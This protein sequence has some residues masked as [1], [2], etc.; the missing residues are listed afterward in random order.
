[1]YAVYVSVY[2]VKNVAR[3]SF[4]V[5]SA[6]VGPYRVRSKVRVSLILSIIRPYSV[7]VT[8]F[9]C[10]DWFHRENM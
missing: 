9:V 7:T 8:Y 6:V 4:R 1:M 10:V 2:A 5:R 3:G